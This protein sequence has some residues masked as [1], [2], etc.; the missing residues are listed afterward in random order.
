M[1][2]IKDQSRIK[3]TFSFIKEG[4]AKI[5][6]ISESSGPI[7]QDFKTFSKKPKVFKPNYYFDFLELMEG[8]KFFKESKPLF[9]CKECGIKFTAAG[10]GGHMSR[11]HFNKSKTFRRRKQTQLFLKIEKDKNKKLREL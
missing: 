1:K 2:N 3:E 7:F 4:Y 5:R 10:M 6:K 11:K 9:K 8:S